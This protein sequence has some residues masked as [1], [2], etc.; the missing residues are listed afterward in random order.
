LNLLT[1]CEL[2]HKHYYTY[3]IQKIDLNFVREI[4]SNCIT[5]REA[6][7]PSN[8]LLQSNKNRKSAAFAEEAGEDGAA[9]VSTTPGHHLEVLGELDRIRPSLFSVGALV[10]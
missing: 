10:S 5:V 8:A 6:E 1:R 9:T 3:S 7:F 4:V 2:L